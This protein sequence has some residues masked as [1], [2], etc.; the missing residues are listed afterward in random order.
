[1]QRDSVLEELMDDP[2]CD[3]RR[4]AATYRRF[5]LVNRAVSGWGGV[6]RAHVRPRLRALGRP[7]R[8][9]DLG[10]GGGDVVV[11]LAGLASRD[12][13]DVE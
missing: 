10:C 3:P 12:G 11:R 13:L 9:L 8:V 7:G 5:D 1:A 4:L 2:D 6:Y